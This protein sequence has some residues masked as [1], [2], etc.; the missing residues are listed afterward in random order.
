MFIPPQRNVHPFLMSAKI[1]A[2]TAG[3]ILAQHRNPSP[4]MMEGFYSNLSGYLSV[5]VFTIALAFS[6]ADSPSLM[7]IAIA[8][9]T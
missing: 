9:A 7:S 2:T 4:S 3:I 5:N 1:P 6:T 8:S